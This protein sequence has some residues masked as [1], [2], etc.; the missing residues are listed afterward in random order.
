LR[1]REKFETAIYLTLL[2]LR[3]LVQSINGKLSKLARSFVLG[4]KFTI[5]HHAF[6]LPLDAWKEAGNR[7]MR[8]LAACPH[9]NAHASHH[10][11]TANTYMVCFLFLDH[12][13]TARF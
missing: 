5:S 1:E 7:G 10:D 8:E 9:S 6:T 12:K 13:H 3:A 11:M 4:A 2:P